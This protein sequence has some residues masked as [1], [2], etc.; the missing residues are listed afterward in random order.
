MYVIAV[1]QSSRTTGAWERELIQRFR[2]PLM[3]ANSGAGG[4]GASGGSPHF[5]YCIFRSDALMRRAP[6]GGTRRDRTER[7]EDFL[8]EHRI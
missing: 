6:G 8:A 7:V 3:C 4:E 1:A 2:Q 5:L